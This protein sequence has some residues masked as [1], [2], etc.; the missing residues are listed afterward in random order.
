VNSTDTA[1]AAR[2]AR[3]GDRIVVRP[4]RFGERTC[5]GEILKVVGEEGQ[6]PFG[7]RWSDDGHVSRLFPGLDA[8]VEH[9]PLPE[10]RDSHR[11]R[12]HRTKEVTS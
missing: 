9:F 3:P 2:C 5:D 8:V 11:T 12:A 10:K 7:V 6:P 1:E 4:H